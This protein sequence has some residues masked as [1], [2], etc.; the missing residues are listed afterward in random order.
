MGPHDSG[1]RMLKIFASAHGKSYP[2]AST[3]AATCSAF[4]FCKVPDNAGI[5]D[6]PHNTLNFLSAAHLRPYTGIG[7]PDTR[8]APYCK[9]RSGSCFFLEGLKAARWRER[10][11]FFSRGMVARAGSNKHTPTTLSP[12]RASWVTAPLA[13]TEHPGVGCAVATS[14]LCIGRVHLVAGG[15]GR[16]TASCELGVPAAPSS[17]SPGDG[18]GL[19]GNALLVVDITGEGRGSL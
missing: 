8:R 2:E 12:R 11:V 14:A 15:S 10:D 1:G 16:N 7:R 3:L 17:S 18:E 5:K 13:T 19:G 9:G 6:G 4:R